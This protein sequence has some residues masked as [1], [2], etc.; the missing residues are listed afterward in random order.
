[1][2]QP[3]TEAIN[4]TT[5]DWSTEAKQYAT[6][7][8]LTQSS[9]DASSNDWRATKHSNYATT[10]DWSNQ[11]DSQRLK[12]W[13]TTAIKQPKTGATNATT[14]DWSNK[15]KHLCNN[16]R[17]KQSSN[18]ATSNCNT[19]Q[20]TATHCNT[21]TEAIKQLCNKQRLEQSSNEGMLQCSNQTLKH[22]SKQ[23]MCTEESLLLHTGDNVTQ[24]QHTATH[25]HTLQHTATH[26]QTLPHTATQKQENKTK[27]SRKRHE[28][29]LSSLGERNSCLT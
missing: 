21:K 22:S 11:S 15:A 2:K 23:R 26:R 1:M 7:S 17:L 27:E 8:R 9:N 29:L 16:Y 25:W 6:T 14:N 20:H 28:K 12:Q 18:D 3:W 5:N 19:L 4:A 13:S 10:N 24:Q